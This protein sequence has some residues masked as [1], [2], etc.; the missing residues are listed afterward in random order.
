MKE[1]ILG[2]DELTKEQKE[3]AVENYK[4]VRLMDDDE[5]CVKECEKYTEEDWYECAECYSYNVTY[6]DDNSYSVLCLF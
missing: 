2:F 3:F 1:V 6:F 4:N 5:E